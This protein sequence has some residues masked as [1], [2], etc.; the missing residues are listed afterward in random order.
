[1]CSGEWRAALPRPAI[2]RVRNGE[3]YQHD[4]GDGFK[5]FRRAVD[6]QPCREISILPLIGELS[7]I[8][9]KQHWGAPFR[10]G[11]VDIPEADFRFIAS[12]ML[13]PEQLA[14]DGY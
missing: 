4:M 5:P 14:E 12:Q 2:G 3:V 10:F 7:F 9:D 6:F 13:A 1:M 8:Q 11:L